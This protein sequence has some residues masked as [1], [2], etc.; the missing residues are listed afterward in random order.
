MLFEK[1][2]TGCHSLTENHEGPQLAGVYGRTSGTVAS[3]AYSPALKKAGVVWDAESLDKWLSD[4]DSLV[5]G[6]AMDFL[7]SRSQ[8][9]QDLI[10]YLKQISGK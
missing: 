1:R 3:Y 7:V 2:C 6:N 5:P 9:R 10:A 8:E 4:P